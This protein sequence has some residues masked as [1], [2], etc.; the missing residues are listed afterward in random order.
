MVGVFVL[1]NNSNTRFGVKDYYQ[2]LGLQSTASTSQIKARFRQL[3]VHYHPDK[4]PSDEAAHIIREINE[5]YDVLS[6]PEKKRKYD[7]RFTNLFEEIATPQHRDPAYRRTRPVRPVV[8]AQFEIMKQ[9]MPYVHWLFKIALVFC[10]FLLLDFF[11]P[12]KVQQ[13]VILQINQ[14]HSRSRG[15]NDYSSNVIY[16]DKGTRIQINLK[17]EYTLEEGDSILIKYSA[18]QHIPLRVDK[19]NQFSVGVPASIYGNFIFVP[20][21]LMVLV[22]FGFHFRKKVRTAFNFGIVILFV[23]LLCLYFINVS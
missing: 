21:V 12:G 10:L 16:T 8:D 19:L 2:I 18:L 5:A 1:V 15:D 13:E 22:G 23:L 6:D 11:L 20:I 7:N 4:N 3:V 17:E 9:S 14:Y